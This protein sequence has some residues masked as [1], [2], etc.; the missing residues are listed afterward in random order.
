MVKEMRNRMRDREYVNRFCAFQ[1]LGRSGYRK[2]TSLGRPD[3]FLSNC[4]RRMNDFNDREFE[5][6]SQGFQNSLRCNYELFGAHA[7]RKS[8]LKHSDGTKSEKDRKPLLSPL[9][10]VMTTSLSHY[11][12]ENVLSRS[13]IIRN[14]YRKL[15]EAKQFRRTLEYFSHTANQVDRRFEMVERMLCG[16]LGP[17]SVSKWE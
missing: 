1:V 4:L 3:L 12:F 10:E 16:I 5:I 6:L 15:L 9:W 8:F 11:D 13:M 2:I 17:P 14:E 7:F